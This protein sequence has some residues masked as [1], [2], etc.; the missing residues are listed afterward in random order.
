MRRDLCPAK[1][2]V[3]ESW[4]QQTCNAFVHVPGQDWSGRP[5]QPDILP[6]APNRVGET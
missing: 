3:L 5:W 6:I 4:G 2:L 1:R